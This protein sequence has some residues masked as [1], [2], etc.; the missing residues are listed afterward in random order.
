[1]D[2]EKLPKTI[3]LEMFMTMQVDGYRAGDIS[4]Q[5]YDK[6][7][8]SSSDHILLRSFTMTFDVPQNVDV[9]GKLIDSLEE[10]KTETMARHHMEIKNI[11]DKLDE[12]LAIEYQPEGK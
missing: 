9:K 4:V 5:D 6:Q 12:L 10:L 2:I 1:M 3:E 8:F 11:Q 7:G